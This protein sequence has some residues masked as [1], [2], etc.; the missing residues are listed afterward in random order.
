MCVQRGLDT[1]EPGVEDVDPVPV[2]EPDLAVDLD[3]AAD[4]VV[5]AAQV[6]QVVV[7][8]VPLAGHLPLED[9]HRAVSQGSQHP[10]LHMP[11][12]RQEIINKVLIFSFR[13]Y[14]VIFHM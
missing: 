10:P 1:H 7:P 2:A 12:A 13:N 3:H 11:A 6:Q 9:G 5:G 4:A 14:K 8:Q